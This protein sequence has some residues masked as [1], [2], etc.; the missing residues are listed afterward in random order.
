MIRHHDVGPLC[1]PNIGVKPAIAKRLKLLEQ[2]PGVYDTAVPKDTD[3]SPNGA[4]R[5][6]RE[7]VFV[8]L[9]DNSVASIIPTLISDDDVGAVAVKI[10][11]AALTLVT[12]LCTD[13]CGGH[14]LEI[15]ATGIYRFRNDR[16][17]LTNR[18]SANRRY[19][20]LLAGRHCRGH[21]LLPRAQPP[22]RRST[23]PVQQLA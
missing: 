9:V 12:E 11:H 3:C 1:H 10:D 4:A 13:N 17:L 22:W 14:Q 2:C 6:Q 8:T 18:S 15:L 7:L 5:D 19:D 20:R 16:P 21:A 23:H